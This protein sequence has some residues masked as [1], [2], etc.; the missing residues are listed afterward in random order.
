MAK[1]SPDFRRDTVRGLSFSRARAFLDG[2][3]LAD[4]WRYHNPMRREYSRE[5]EGWMHPLAKHPDPEKKW[6]KS[7]PC[8]SW[9]RVDHVLVPRRR[10]AAA[11][12][13][14][15]SSIK[16][17]EK[18]RKSDHVPVSVRLEQ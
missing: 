3:E 9:A 13:T 2:A 15:H 17:H 5:D 11:T 7:K 8:G 16:P 12:A 18:G 1:T 10:V 14:I 6:P 4:A